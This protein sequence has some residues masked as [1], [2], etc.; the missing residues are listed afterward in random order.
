MQ[1]KRHR[2]RLRERAREQEREREEDWERNRNG[3]LPRPEHQLT[4][5]DTL[6]EAL[7]I[8]EVR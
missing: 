6:P 2:N 7:K 8:A 5:N 4:Y 3:L 1:R